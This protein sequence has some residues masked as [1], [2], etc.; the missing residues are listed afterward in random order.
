M[1]KFLAQLVI[2]CIT[3]YCTGQELPLLHT[4]PTSQGHRGWRLELDATAFLR[5]AAF[6]TP[7]TRGYTATGFFL[8]PM[9]HYGIDSV[10]RLTVGLHL[11]GVAGYD[12][13]RAWNPLVRLEYA[14][15]RWL[16]LVMGTL[17][18]GL[19]H[20]VGEAMLDRER[21]IYDHQEEG[22]QLLLHAGERFHSD[23]WLHWENLLEPWQMDQERFTLG[24]SNELMLCG[25]EHWRVALL[26]AFV[27][28]HR[29]GQFSALDTCIQSLFNESAGLRVGFS[30][31]ERC[32]LT[33]ELPVYLY[34]DISP[35]PCLAYTQGWGVWPQ[36]GYEGR[37]RRGMLLLASAGYWH[38]HQYIAPRGSYLFQGVSW[39]LAD[40]AAPE[41]DMVTLRAALE[42]P[43]RPGC[44]FGAD[45]EA[46]YDLTSGG[47]DFAF[48]VY[49]R[50]R[51][52]KHPD[53]H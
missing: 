41:R 51:I 53:V 6:E 36:I 48:G 27:G 14:P 22:M 25:G 29:G 35:T 16:R 17:Y 2:F 42:R 13:L 19:S 4:F 1:K 23:T 11:A 31:T 50:Y 5:D 21:W 30:P 46:Y 7:Y 33:L 38:G 47:L 9:A 15:C 26:L 52:E 18:G 37:S 45:A 44:S 12:G 8:D 20:G 24:S 40:F 49:L 39:H 32:R 10:A 43:I 3:A 34:Q 28:S